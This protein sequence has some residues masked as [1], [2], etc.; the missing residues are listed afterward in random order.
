LV[1]LIGAPASFSALA[2][3][4]FTLLSPSMT[5]VCA[6]SVDSSKNF[7]TRPS[8]ILAMTS[9]GLPDSLACSV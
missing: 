1:T 2:M 6:S 3:M 8:T 4:S 5:K 9:A 7:R